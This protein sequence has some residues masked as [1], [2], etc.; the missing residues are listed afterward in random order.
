MCVVPPVLLATAIRE[1][2]Y[3]AVAAWIIVS[4]GAARHGVRIECSAARWN[5]L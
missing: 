2:S 3:C 4:F 1:R 5:L